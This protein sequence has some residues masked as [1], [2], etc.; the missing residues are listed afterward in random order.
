M[1]Y[2][3]RDR[4]VRLLTPVHG[5]ISAL[6]RGSR[7]STKRYGGALDLG[8]RIEAELRPGRGE[9]WH[10]N[11]AHLEEGRLGVRVD[12]ERMGLLAYLTEVN[13]ALARE[14][15]PEPKLF[16]L[17]ETALALLD[18]AD[19]PPKGLFRLAHEAKALTFAGLAPV[20]DRCLDCDEGL[21]GGA[22][23]RPLVILPAAGGA[24]HRECHPGGG[25]PVNATFLM[26][27][28]AAR[29]TPLRDLLDAELPPGPAWVLSEAVEAHLGRGLKTRSV[30]TALARPG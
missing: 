27:V 2:R 6:A 11:G 21:D 23:D 20:L 24:F 3:D 22:P 17:L 5:R 26:A 8:N 7:G 28:E 13:H 12:L 30:L 10:L 14:A 18:H 29:R 1:D 25:K 4:I 16:G 19:A 9:L 15:H